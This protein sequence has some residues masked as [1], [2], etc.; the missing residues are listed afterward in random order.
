MCVGCSVVAFVLMT[1]MVARRA[2]NA[3]ADENALCGVL[4][5]VLV[6]AS[7][8]Y[9]LVAVVHILYLEGAMTAWRC[10]EQLAPEWFTWGSSML[11]F[12][13][14][15]I[16][17]VFV[18]YHFDLVGASHQIHH[19]LCVCCAWWHLHNIEQIQQWQPVSIPP[20]LP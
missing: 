10:L 15:R 16:P 18:P 14:M 11:F 13:R 5:A 17:E 4:P 3:G 8:S 7:F 1:C 6:C 9:W 12:W 2:A 19:I 20:A